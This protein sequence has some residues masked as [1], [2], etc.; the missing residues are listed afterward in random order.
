M[1]AIFFGLKRAFHGTLRVGTELT[2]DFG[3][4]P[5][6]FDL[7]FVLKQWRDQY[8]PTFALSQRGLRVGLGVSA[9]TVSRMLRSLEKLRLVRRGPRK[10]HYKT[11]RPVMLTERGRALIRRAA[12]RIVFN[13]RARRIADR[14][15]RSG[16][17]NNAFLRR[18]SLE[19]KLRTMRRFLGDF[20]VLYY[21]W[22]PD[23]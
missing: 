23:D 9:P 15:L 13:K 17:R 4:T 7:L 3:L 12:K 16:N 8:P 22:H 6:R 5:A 10:H 11:S 19:E 21:A 1:D 20:A 2:K 18:E 14:A